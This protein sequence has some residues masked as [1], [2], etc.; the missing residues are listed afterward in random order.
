M[1]KTIN[2][3]IKKLEIKNFLF[4][5]IF[6]KKENVSKFENKNFMSLNSIDSMSILKIILKIE[7][8]FKIKL[9]DNIIFSNKFKT[10]KGITDIIIKKIS[11]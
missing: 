3:K 1:K 9:E 4:K 5:I 2:L 6:K 10:I 11:H 8:K 7:D